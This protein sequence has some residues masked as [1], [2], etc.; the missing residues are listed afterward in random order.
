MSV[1]RI[2]PGEILPLVRRLGGVPDP[3]ALYAALTEGGTRPDTLLLESADSAAGVGQR[4]LLVVRSML[5][6]TCR[7]C[8]VEAAVLSTNGRALCEGVGM[9]VGAEV[10]RDAAGRTGRIGSDLDAVPGSH[11]LDATVGEIHRHSGDLR[12]FAA[13][14]TRLSATPV[15]DRSVESGPDLDERARLLAPGPLD[16]LREAVLRPRVLSDAGPFSYFAAGIFGY[17]LVDHFESLPGPQYDAHGFPDF[18][19]WIPDRAILVDHLHRTTT[20]FALVAGG[21]DAEAA[22]HDAARDVERLARAVSEIGEHP[23]STKPLHPGSLPLQQPTHGPGRLSCAQQEGVPGGMEGPGEHSASRQGRSIGE[24]LAGDNAASLAL[25]KGSTHA[26]IGTELSET[27]PALPAS[28][29]QEPLGV[30]LTDEAFASLVRKLQEHVAAGDVFQIVPSRTFT[31]GCADPLGAY[32]RLRAEN[33]TPYQFFIR[34]PEFVLFGASPE[35]AV[36]VDAKPGRITIRPIAGTVPRGRTPGGDPDP[37]MDARLQ[38]ALLTSPKELAEHLMLVDLARNDVARV[39][40]PGTRIVSRLLALEGYRHVTHLVSE[41]TGELADGLD[42]LHAYAATLNMGTLVGAPKIRA[43][44]L[45]RLHETT[46]RGAYGGAV[47]FLTHDGAL[48]S[49]IVIRSAFVKDGIAS[50]RVGAGVVLDSNPE[51]EAEETK[52]KAA[53]VLRALGAQ[54]AS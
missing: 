13:D 36:R 42:A 12:L 41:V 46:K 35:M 31:I 49:A 18:I 23:A 29:C 26:F 37:E 10:K 38:A 40:R 43:A 1:P 53:A 25:R 6:L 20:L 16:A 8:R 5:R 39:S 22:Y 48:D 11:T 32:A 50:V 7:G 47:G 27:A 54:V 3:L 34:S 19:F 44:Q 28:S 51:S 17:D 9:H 2:G 33:P 14:R 52:H 30:D 15:L 45:L 4:S 21:S 24:D